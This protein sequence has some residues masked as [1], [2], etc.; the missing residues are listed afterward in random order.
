MEEAADPDIL[1][2]AIAGD[3]EAFEA[4][5]RRHYDRIHGLAW[6]LTGSRADA[7]DITQDVCCILAE[8]LSAFRGDAKFTTWLCSIVYNACR[9]FHRRR[10]AFT[11]F[12]GRLSIMAG[13]A[14]GPDGRD[15][16][17]ALWIESAIAR[18]KPDLRDT[19][20][21]IAGQQLS[22]A[23]AAQILG[24]AEATVSWRMHEV[25]R[26]LAAKA[27]PED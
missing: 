2:A 26:Q 8:K 14:R 19:A 27:G 1:A 16:Y 5:L 22:H 6:Q 17:D 23:E 24:V 15:L 4:L 21:L 9:D 10:S 20:I 7:D 18:L 12:A 25:R 3:R 11:R 13:L